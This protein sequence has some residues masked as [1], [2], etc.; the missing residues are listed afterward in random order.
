MTNLQ[1]YCYG[2]KAFD[3]ILKSKAKLT[4]DTF[5]NELFYLWDIYSEEMIEEI[6]RNA[7]MNDELF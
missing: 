4:S 6:V 7:E 1:C 5:F 2:V 3:N